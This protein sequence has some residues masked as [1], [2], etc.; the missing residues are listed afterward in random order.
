MPEIIHY[1]S[2]VFVAL[3]TSNG[4]ITDE[5]KTVVTCAKMMDAVGG[6]PRRLLFLVFQ[7]CTMVE[8]VIRDI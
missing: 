7:S 6:S 4:L 2:F 3:R 5:Y 8:R 1:A